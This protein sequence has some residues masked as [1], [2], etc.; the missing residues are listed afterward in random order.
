MEISTKSV[1]FSFNEIM[2]RQIEGV[3]MG[4]PLGPILV[5]IF[6]GFQER[7]LFEKFPKPFIYLRYVD[8]SFVSFRS[9]NDALLFFDKL[10]DLHSSLSLTIKLPFLD[11]LVE[12]CDSFL[13]SVYRK[14]TFTGLYLSWDSFASRSRKLN[15]I[16][17]LSFR[18]LNICCESKI[19]DEL[20]V[21][22]ETFINNGY[23]EEVP[24]IGLGVKVFANGPGDLGSIPGRVI[25]KTQK[26]VLDASLLNTQHYKVRIKGKIE[27]SR[28][29]VAPSP[30]HWCSSDRK[31][32]LQVTLDYGR[33]LYLFIMRKPL[34]IISS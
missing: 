5:N 27:Q 4:S 31:G 15:L 10:N 30:T 34:M 13:T 33:Q 18:A 3:S 2:Y 26:M 28:E 29:G 19:E 7:L 23:H 16:R 1:S 20:K 24:D 22:K 9:R 11:V 25:P 6:V 12:R 8:D 21:I 17:C 14:P 32:S